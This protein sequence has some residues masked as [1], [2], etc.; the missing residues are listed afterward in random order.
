[1]T[2]GAIPPLMD[3]TAPQYLR[4]PVIGHSVWVTKYHDDERWPCG[5]YP[6]QSTVDDGMTRWISDDEP[7]ENTDVVLWHVFGIHHIT[8]VEDW[9]IMPADIVSFWLKP[10]GFFDQNPSIDVAPTPKADD[11]TCHTGTGHHHPH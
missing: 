10:F 4:A 9:P 6:T 3:P 2:F 7:L 8:R 11:E 1:V 5:D